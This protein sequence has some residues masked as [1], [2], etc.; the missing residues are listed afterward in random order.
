MQVCTRQ[1]GSVRGA[2]SQVFVNLHNNRSRF[3][4]IFWIDANSDETAKQSYARISKIGGVEANESAAKNWLSTLQQP[5]LLLVDNADEPELDVMRYIPR[6]EGGVV[7][8]TSRNPANR[9]HGTEGPRFFH[10]EKLAIN[11]ASDL[12][13]AVADLP[14]PWET[15]I[16]KC[17]DKI[18]E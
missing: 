7:L 9:R 2:S 10:F 12:L 17:A 14:R 6:G 16:R 4:G 1:Q 13:L 11:E 18:A 15:P 5:W 3:W 8:I